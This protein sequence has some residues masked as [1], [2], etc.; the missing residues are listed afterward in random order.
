MTAQFACLT[1]ALEPENAL[2]VALPNA[3]GVPV[4]VAVVRDDDGEWHAISDI[5]SHGQVSLS[6]GEVEGCAIECWLHGSA[7][8]LRTGAPQSLPAVRP[9]PVYPLTIEGNSVLVDVDITL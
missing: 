4:E 9:V 2:A 8:D 3:A 1:S 7:F 6:Q 5:C